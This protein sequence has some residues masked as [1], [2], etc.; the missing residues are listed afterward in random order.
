MRLVVTIPAYNEAAD[1]GAVIEEIPRA[2]PGVDDVR[3]LVLDDGSSDNTAEVART[4]GADWVLSNGANRG[5]AFTFQRAMLEALRRGADI[6]VNTDADNHYDQT[7][8][9]RLAEPVVAGQADVSV[10]SRVLDDVEMPKAN[11]YGNRLG[12]LAMQRVLGIEGI[13]VSTG[14]RAY[15]KEAALRTVVFSGHTYTHET[16]LAALDQRLAVVHV[17]IA[18]RSVSRPSRLIKSVPRHVVYAGTT[19]ARSLALYRP[20]HTYLLVGILV[21]IV[22]LVPIARFLFEYAS[23]NGE[24]HIQS[25]VIGAAAIYLSG[26]IVIAGVIASAVRANRRLLQETLR[27]TRELLVEQSLASS[28]ESTAEALPDTRRVA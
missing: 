23:G 15:S 28:R 20:L 11:R 6:V 17:P 3:V 16:L 12:N 13:D 1:I 22:G 9:P 8:I 24:G 26:Q 14:F 2:I 21:G 19:I 25:L 7:A 10:G 5:L 4:A 18:A 27:N